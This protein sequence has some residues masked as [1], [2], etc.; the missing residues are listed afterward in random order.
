MGAVVLV[1]GVFD[2][3]DHKVSLTILFDLGIPFDV[4]LKCIVHLFFYAASQNKTE[5]VDKR[6]NKVVVVS[7]FHSRNARGQGAAV[8]KM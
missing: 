2:V 7:F 1:E 6:G 4:P 3:A 5:S 8:E